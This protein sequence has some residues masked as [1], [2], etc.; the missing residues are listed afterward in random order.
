MKYN[1][2]QKHESALLHTYVLNEFLSRPFIYNKI[3]LKKAILEVGSSHLY[4]SFGT[5]C[6]QIGQLLKTQGVF[7]VFENRQMAV[8]EGKY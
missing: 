1:A 8:I 5:F 3:F 2:S 6:I 4:A 7:E